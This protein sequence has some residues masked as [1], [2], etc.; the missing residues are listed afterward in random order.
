MSKMSTSNF[1]SDL[2]N[3][4]TT[5]LVCA[6]FGIHNLPQSLD[7]G[8]NSEGVISGF[9]ISGQSL[10]KENCHNSRTSDDVDMK[11][12]PE[13]ELDKRN[14]KKHQKMTMTSCRKIVM[15]LTFFRFWPI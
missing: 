1:E 4:F 10:I 2:S 8:Q 14:K 5:H 12:V 13:T 6:K 7:I 11:L 3:N 15:S 9:Q